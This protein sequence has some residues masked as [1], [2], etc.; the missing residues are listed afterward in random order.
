MSANTDAMAQALRDPMTPRPY[1][2]LRTQREL[3]DTVTLTLTPQD[4]EAV[5]EFAPGQFNMLYVFGTGDIAIS[6]SS[7]PLNRTVL[8]HTIR[9]VGTVSRA[10]RELATSDTIGVRGPFGTGWPLEAAE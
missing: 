9:A 1:R 8:T 2:I 7:D 6:I 4:G 3:A 5:M 10:M